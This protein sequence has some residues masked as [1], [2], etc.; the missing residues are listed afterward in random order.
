M[1][2]SWLGD[3]DISEVT[4]QLLKEYSA[5][6]SDRLKPSSLGHCIRFVRSLFRFA[7]EEGHMTRNPKSKKAHPRCARQELF[8]DTFYD[9]ICTLLLKK[10]K[11]RVLLFNYLRISDS[12]VTM[13]K[14]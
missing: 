13:Q 4:L 6:Q 8:C 11:V 5:K 1:L 14:P 12:T 3:I 2:I 7:F 10:L 9:N